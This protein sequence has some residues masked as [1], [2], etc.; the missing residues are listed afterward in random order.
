VRVCDASTPRDGDGPLYTIQ[1][2]NNA[3]P[4]G[5]PAL[6]EVGRHFPKEMDRQTAVYEGQIGDPGAPHKPAREGR[7]GQGARP[8]IR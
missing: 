1:K 2:I 8:S 6:G 5:V 7:G 4:P 3:P